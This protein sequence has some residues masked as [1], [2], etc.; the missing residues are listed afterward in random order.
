M[1]SPVF[2]KDRPGR[3]LCWPMSADAHRYREIVRHVWRTISHML[4]AFGEGVA[5]ALRRGRT[6]H[7]LATMSD[8]ELHDIGINRSDISAVV[9]GAYQK[10]PSPTSGP[11]SHGRRERS[12]SERVHDV[13][14]AERGACVERST[15]MQE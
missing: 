12:R 5:E 15:A 3:A 7:E 11:S 8:P 9:S 2:V 10:T 14:Y 13:Q 1:N 4:M 6:Y